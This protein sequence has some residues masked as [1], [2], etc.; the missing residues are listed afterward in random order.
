MNNIITLNQNSNRAARSKYLTQA[1]VSNGRHM[2]SLREARENAR[3]STKEAAEAA[4][5]TLR[6]LKRWE[7]DCGRADSFAIGRLCQFY[8]ISLGHVH[9][10]KEADLLAAR[11]EVSNVEKRTFEVDDL[12]V[13][14]KQMGRDTTE[15]EKFV[16]ETRKS[17]EAEIKNALS[18]GAPE[19]FSELH[20]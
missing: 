1:A 11:R 2:I 17:R 13:V 5:I 19:T 16:E 15:L 14:L 9:A 10:G 7:M 3:R 8:G 6:T 12:I 4:G 20:M 18:V